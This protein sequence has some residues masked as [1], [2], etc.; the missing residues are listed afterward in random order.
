MEG[1]KINGFYYSVNMEQIREHQK[2]SIAEIFEWLH[3]TNQF[4]KQVQTD[5]EKEI[6]DRF[7][8]PHKYNSTKTN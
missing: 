7:R 3:S 4:L 6:M 5:E 2:K 1:N 8:N